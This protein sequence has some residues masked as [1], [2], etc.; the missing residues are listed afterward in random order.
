[1]VNAVLDQARIG[2][3]DFALQ[4]E[5]VD[6]AAL[7]R[8]IV[9]E[10]REPALAKGLRVAVD[11]RPGPHLRSDPRLVRLLL[12]HLLENAVKFTDRGEVRLQLDAAQGR[13]SVADT[14]PG[15]APE[16]R[17]RLF[18]PFREGTDVAHKHAPGLGLGLAIVRQAVDVLG[19]QLDLDSAPGAGSTFTV[20]L[21]PLSPA[22][23]A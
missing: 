19:G 6:I 8:E 13:L 14:G 5:D 4:A 10:L 7:A 22:E 23:A 3:R 15:I 12:R 16:H 20:T 2:S 1:V 9:A 18:E 11:A 21:P 17:A